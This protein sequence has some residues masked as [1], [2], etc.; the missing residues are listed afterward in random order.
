MGK[1][2]R[3]EWSYSAGEW[4]VNRVRA[5]NRGS[6][7]LYLE[8]YAGSPGAERKRERLALGHRDPERAK[9]Q[10]DALAAKL[11]TCSPTQLKGPTLEAVLQPYLREVSANKGLGKQKHD[12]RA[13]E[14][15]LRFFGAEFDVR[16]FTIRDRDRF[17]TERRAGRIAPAGVTKLRTV[18]D[19]VIRYDWA[20]LAAAVRW[21][22]R[23]RIIE[24]NPLDGLTVADEK[25]PRS[26]ALTREQ[27][28]AL[29]QVAPEVHPLFP[30]LLVLAFET[31]HRGNAIRQLRWSD[32]SL[33]RRVIRWRASSDKLGFEH[34]TPLSE[35][36]HAALLR[37][38]RERSSLEDGWVFPSERDPAKPWPREAITRCWRR[39]ALRAKLPTGQRL[40]LHAMRRTFA[41]ELKD[42][43]NLKDLAALGGWKSTTTLLRCYI[44]PDEQTQRA[45]LAKR[46]E[47]RAV[48]AK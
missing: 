38:W 17:V 16:R 2:K 42:E 15:F 37:A 10:A 21:A 6:K 33:D 32:V 31:G 46:R 34:E 23:A 18:R 3:G 14:M 8:W 24:S 39:T 48:A 40:G 20:F 41:T 25:N 4:G 12:E 35:S 7:G 44:K 29:R 1:G 9:E 22:Y 5:F 27:Y 13:A 26:P 19:R 45:A 28:E 30:L 11:R 36:A 43:V 47:L